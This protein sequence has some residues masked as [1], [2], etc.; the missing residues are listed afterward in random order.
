MRDK[1]RKRLRRRLLVA[2][3][4]GG[5]E[6]TGFSSGILKRTA[7]RYQD[8]AVSWA[9]LDF[10]FSP[11][12]YRILHAKHIISPQSYFFAQYPKRARCGSSQAKYPKR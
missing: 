12:K 3:G 1:P 4:G 6:K 2:P 9:S 5:E 11:M 8:P 7:K 10:F